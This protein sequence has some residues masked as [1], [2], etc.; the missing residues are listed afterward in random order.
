MLVD[1]PADELDEELVEEPGEE[2]VAAIAQMKLGLFARSFC[3][4]G[5][6]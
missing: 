5:A 4:L 6:F 3:K 2:L 1:D